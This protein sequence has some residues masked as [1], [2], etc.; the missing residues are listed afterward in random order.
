MNKRAVTPLISSL[1]LIFFAVILGVIVMSWGNSSPNERSA[2]QSC[3]KASIRVI[4]INNEEQ[5]C[6]K[7]GK[8]YFTL[9]NNGEVTLSGA[10]I[11]IIGSNSIG[12]DELNSILTVG[13]IKRLEAAYNPSIGTLM[14]IRFTPKM[15]SGSI[16]G[17]NILKVENIRECR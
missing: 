6:Y 10:K 9:E 11:S 16:C 4:S 7:N 1:M 13:D 3:D 17:A 2:V 8:A 5:V 14:Q 15:R 12:Q